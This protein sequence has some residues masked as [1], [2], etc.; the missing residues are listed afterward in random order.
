MIIN[1]FPSENQQFLKDILR[2][3]MKGDGVSWFVAKKLRRLM[4]DESLRVMV[5]NRLY[6]APSAD[7]NSDA[8]DDMVSWDNS[9]TVNACQEKNNICCNWW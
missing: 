3:V 9:N 2:G 6:S 7:K 8:V 1:L 4:C 5:A